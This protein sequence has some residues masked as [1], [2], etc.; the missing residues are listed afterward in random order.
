M[1]TPDNVDSQ[2]P[3]RRTR[4]RLGLRARPLGV[5]TRRARTWARRED[6]QA[7]VEVALALPVLLILVTA[8]LA[9]GPM[10]STYS[11]LVDA[12]R[13]GVRELSIGRGLSDPCDPA[14]LQ[15]IE[16]MAGNSG[17]PSKDVTVSFTA[18]ASSTNTTPDSCG[19]TPAC[20]YVYNTSCNTNGNENQNDEATVA[21]AEPYTLRVFG[22][23]VM[24]VNLSTSSSEPIE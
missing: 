17:L 2:I 18:N 6:G 16:S 24:T 20:P 15:T 23:N 12:S 13:V 10:Y 4:G 22:M 14:V 1:R 19:S 11:A 9:F 3:E 5:G 7:L 21:V 8:I